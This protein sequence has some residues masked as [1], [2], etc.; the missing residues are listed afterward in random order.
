M[1]G[2]THIPIEPG[3]VF[4][5]WTVIGRSDK[6]RPNKNTYYS[7]QCECG[8]T[9]DVQS[10]T[11]RRGESTCCVR[12]MNTKP[13]TPGT[14]YGRWTVIQRTYENTPAHTSCTYYMCECE[15][16]GQYAIPSVTLRAGK[17]SSCAKCR[18]VAKNTI[19]SDEYINMSVHSKETYRQYLNNAQS[20]GMCFMLTIPEFLALTAGNCHYCGTP[21]QPRAIRGR[22]WASNGIDRVDNNTGYVASNCVSCCKTCNLSKKDMPLAEWNG[23][24]QRLIAH[25]NHLS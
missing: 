22:V 1:A 18:D 23:W 4:G 16:G 21:P 12:C 14:K 15:C 20:R 6:S 11:L 3:T 8:N 24:I 9:K 10:G 17:S 7:C 2:K 5:K 13:I 19:Q 25:Q